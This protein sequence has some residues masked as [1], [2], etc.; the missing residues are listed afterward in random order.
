MRLLDRKRLGRHF[1]GAVDSQQRVE[2]E[3]QDRWIPRRARDPNRASRVGDRGGRSSE[4][5]QRVRSRDQPERLV[6]RAASRAARSIASVA[7]AIAAIKSASRQRQ[8]GPSL[9][10]T[11]L[12]QPLVPAAGARDGSRGLLQQPLG[13]AGLVTAGERQQRVDPG[14]DDRRSEPDSSC[15]LARFGLK[16]L[17]SLE[18]EQ[19]KCS[20]ASMA[21]ARASIGMAPSFRPKLRASRNTS[22]LPHTGPSRSGSTR[23][24]RGRTG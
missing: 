3:Q 9:G 2:R 21:V 19:I 18:V 14:A 7:A 11:H 8:F 1:V 22:W 5:V 16:R 4:R 13:P 20:P 23:G 24:A 10:Q 17:R 6:F 12:P 15:Q